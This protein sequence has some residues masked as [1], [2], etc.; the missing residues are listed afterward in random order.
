MVVQMIRQFIERGEL[1]EEDQEDIYEADA[2]K[3]IMRYHERL[4]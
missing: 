4:M 1:S 3:E 2:L